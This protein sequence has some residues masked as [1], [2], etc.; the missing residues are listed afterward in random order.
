[1]NR[2]L[3]RTCS[4]A[5]RWSARHLDC[6]TVQCCT[7]RWP[8]VVRC[9]STSSVRHHFFESRD[10][11]QEEKEKRLI[12]HQ[13]EYFDQVAKQERNRQ[14]FYKAVKLYLKHNPIYR[15]GHVEFLYAALDRLQEFDAH[16]DLTTYKQ[17]MTL[18]PENK[19]VAQGPWDVEWMYYPK[20]QQCAMDIMEVMETNG[21]FCLLF[22]SLLIYVCDY[23]LIVAQS[24]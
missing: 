11:D 14:T 6:N 22:S 18:F 7:V 23:L 10:E 21:E 17:L 5:V 3:L 19:M 12:V 2:N 1:M 15:R 9:V 20:Q 16:R 8:I 4:L 24:Q 13:G